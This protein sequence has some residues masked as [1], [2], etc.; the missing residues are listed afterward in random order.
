MSAEQWLTISQTVKAFPIF[1]EA[2]LRNLIRKANDNGLE[3][4]IRR[5]GGRV[6]FMEPEFRH[7]LEHRHILKRKTSSG[8]GNG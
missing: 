4:A 8:Q 1:T 2:A 3:P 6:Y 5:I 7:W